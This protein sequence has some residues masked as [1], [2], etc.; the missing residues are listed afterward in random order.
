M[1]VPSIIDD[2]LAL[3]KE[4]IDSA[5]K[6]L[7]TL[8]FLAIGGG[9]L[10][11]ERGVDLV[12]SNVKLLNHYG[13]TEIGAIA[14]IFCPGPDYNWRYLRL[15]TDLGL[16]LHPIPDTE[17]FRLVGYPCGWGKS[18]EVQDQ[19]ERNP[20]SKHIEVRILGRTDDVL[21]L[22]TG[23][24]VMPQKL[25]DR[26]NR[27]AN[28]QAAV[29]VGTDRF[30]VAVIV[31]PV[32]EEAADPESVIDYVWEQISEINPSLDSHARVSSKQSIIIKP[33][34]KA[35]PRSDKGSV[36]R[37]EVCEVFS[38]EIDD[39]YAAME[40]S[41][42]GVEISLN[43]DD[44]E[45]EIREAV[46]A[47][48]G[49]ESVTTRIG[50]EEDFFE[51]GMNSMQA[52]R[53]ARSLDAALRRIKSPLG[54]SSWKVTADFV[55]RHSSVQQLVAACS[56]IIMGD[57][58]AGSSV[59]HD[60]ISEM[61]GL[62]D[63]YVD[64]VTGTASKMPMSAPCHVVLLTGATGTLGTHTLAQLTR[65]SSVKK[66]V[67]LVR[68]PGATGSATNPMPNE[69]GHNSLM[70]KLLKGMESQGLVL[71]PSEWAKVTTIDSQPFF[72]KTGQQGQAEKDVSPDIL[73]R[74]ASEVTHICHLAW[75]MDFKRTLKSFRPHISFLGKLVELAISAKARQHYMPPVRLVFAS[76]IA[77][78]RYR[79]TSK[80]DETNPSYAERMV[81]ETAIDDPSVVTPMGYAEA[82]WVCERILDKVGQTRRA[83]VDPVIVRIGQISGPASTQGTWKTIEHIPALVR[84]SQIVGAF[85]AAQGVSPTSYLT[86]FSNKC[87]P[88]F[89][90]RKPVTEGIM[91][92]C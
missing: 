3:P 12:E 38:K 91:A 88:I 9:A 6:T 63:E 29:C 65:T 81:P 27:D 66:V 46:D 82:K 40:S 35:I 71:T 45:G 34:G 36:M 19:L 10:N 18:F 11:P 2:I 25:E 83:Q 89:A 33:V 30:E 1:T 69:N 92:S 43:S 75:P 41:A 80:H 85:P 87:P 32:N 51:F 4:E 70:D 57:Y 17:Y 73:F 44:I 13:V 59:G 5:L 16:E 61:R 77:V 67:C 28:I 74:L 14:P 37:R 42:N 31:Q 58:V 23:E 76:S 49:R 54:E 50:G 26:L 48:L 90:N 52:V 20:D 78:M 62:V 55:Y 53:L 8:H 21:V 7:A 24:K 64:G 68:R 84:A 47:I 60:A 86:Y 72:E 56:R 15:R 39:A 79:S 22:K